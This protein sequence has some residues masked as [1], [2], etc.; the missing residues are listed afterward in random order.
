MKF[1]ILIKRADSTVVLFSIV[2]RD[3]Q[4]MKIVERIVECLDINIQPD[5]VKRMEK[6]LDWSPSTL[7]TESRIQ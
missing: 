3:S 2:V 6:W 5:M 7:M 4:L 1:D